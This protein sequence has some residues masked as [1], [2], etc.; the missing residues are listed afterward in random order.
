MRRFEKGQRVKI[1]RMVTKNCVHGP[2]TFP[3]HQSV[4]HS[5]VI[6][7]WFY[8]GPDN[9]GEQGYVQL[10]DG[11]SAGVWGDCLIQPK[12]LTPFEESIMVYIAKE[13][14]ELGLV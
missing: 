3:D 12:P 9:G 5:G 2:F 4:G 10:D 8:E 13:K 14:A 1:Y 7:T 6:T 11:R